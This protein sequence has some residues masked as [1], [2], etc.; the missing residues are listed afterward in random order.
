LSRNKK[1]CKQNINKFSRKE[2]KQGPKATRV[3]MAPTNP[4]TSVGFTPCLEPDITGSAPLLLKE[5]LR[6]HP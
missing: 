5:T 3:E 1:G 6:L 2:Q 4:Y